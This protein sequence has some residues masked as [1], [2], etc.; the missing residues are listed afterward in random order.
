M[1]LGRPP[2]ARFPGR[3]EKLSDQPVVQEDLDYAVAQV[4]GGFVARR[5]GRG[6]CSGGGGG[7]GGS[8]RILVPDASSC[9]HDV[10]ASVKKSNHRPLAHPPV[11]SV[12]Y[13]TTRTVILAAGW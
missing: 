8:G 4:C 5:G 10:L 7:G 6:S 2:T 13:P 3:D 12:P 11:S 1:D 9:L